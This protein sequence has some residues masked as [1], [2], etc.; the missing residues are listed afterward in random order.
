M[1]GVTTPAIGP[2]ALRWWHGSRLTDAAGLEERDRVLGVV[3]Q[4]L[5]S[6]AAHERAA[7]RAGGAGPL[8]RRAGVQELARLE[9]EHLGGRGDVDEVGGDAEHRLDGACGWRRGGGG[10][11]ATA[12]RSASVPGIGG[13]QSTR[14]TSTAWPATASANMPAPTV[15]TGGRWRSSERLRAARWRGGWPPRWRGGPRRRR[16]RGRRSW[17]V[18]ALRVAVGADHADDH[19]IAVGRAAAMAGASSGG[20][21]GLGAVAEHEVEQDDAGA[22]G[23]PRPGPAARGAASGRSSGARG[24]G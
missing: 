6:G 17:R 20:G 24:P 18:E 7:Q 22:P 19:R 5:E 13:R 10:S 9:A 1:D 8:D 21:V 4:A 2:T 3:D 16:R 15:T 11:A 23:R 12:A 14:S